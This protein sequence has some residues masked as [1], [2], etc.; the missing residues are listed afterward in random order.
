MRRS[1]STPMSMSTSTPPCS[2]I[3]STSVARRHGG[4][5]SMGRPSYVTLVDPHS[6]RT[7]WTT[8]SSVIRIM[9]P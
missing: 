7:R 9:S 8:S 6:S 4:V 2:A 1:S 5:K 3:N